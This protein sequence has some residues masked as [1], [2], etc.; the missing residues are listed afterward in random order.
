[1]TRSRAADGSDAEITA[2]QIVG[3]DFASTVIQVHH[4]D[5]SYC[6]TASPLCAP[7]VAAQGS[8]PRGSP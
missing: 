2:S 3:G 8:V 5:F 6:V 1:M 7:R 4:V